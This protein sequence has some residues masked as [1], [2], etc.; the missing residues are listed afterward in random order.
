MNFEIP[1]GDE[2][3]AGIQFCANCET[4]ATRVVEH[5]DG[6]DLFLC[7]TCATAYEWGQ[8]SPNDL[9]VLIDG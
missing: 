6:S 8:S 1:V 2:Q 7:T 5:D 9:V 4:E 3:L